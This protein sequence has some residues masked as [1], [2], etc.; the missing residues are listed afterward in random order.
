[1]ADRNEFSFGA[2]IICR[3]SSSRIPGKTLTRAAGKPLIQY[4]V[5]RLQ[6][7]ELDLKLAVATST[8]S[9]DDPIADF[10]C[11]ARLPLVRGS[12]KDVAGRFLHAIELLNCVAVFR[13]NGDSPFVPSHLFSV[14]AQIMQRTGCDLVTNIF[15]RR[16]PP[17]MSLELI[18]AETYRRVYQEITADEDRE[19]VTRYLYRNAN[20]FKLHN[21]SSEA[22]YSA[23]RFAVDTPHDLA[24]FTGMVNAMDRP[25]WTYSLEDLIALQRRVSETIAEN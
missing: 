11:K 21:L 6:H 3:M 22:D 7:V 20:H 24:L 4:I 13:V 23:Y 25:H 15:P 14:A 2:A 10:A 1:M 9:S 12:L 5:D 8:D 17:G 16:F 19:H 18:R